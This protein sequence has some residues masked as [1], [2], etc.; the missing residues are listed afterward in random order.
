MALSHKRPGLPP[1]HTPHQTPRTQSLL[2][3]SQQQRA[4]EPRL[5]GA[6]WALGRRRGDADAPVERHHAGAR[7]ADHRLQGQG[8]AHRQVRDEPGREGL[9]VRGR[10]A[11]RDGGARVER[12]A[13]RRAA[14]GDVCGGRGPVRAGHRP[15]GR[16]VRRR[17]ER[18]HRPLVR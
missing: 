3:T 14:G 2:E 9:G 7:A 1:T 8:Q 10:A 5:T 18:P 4:R 13:V 17:L 16:R 12:G 15:R 11:G 6:R